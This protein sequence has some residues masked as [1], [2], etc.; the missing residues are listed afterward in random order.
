MGINEY[1]GIAFSFYFR[2]LWLTQKIGKFPKIKIISLII[3][4]LKFYHN[5]KVVQNDNFQ[6]LFRKFASLKS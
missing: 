1:L 5:K 2:K 6:N 3:S 4:V